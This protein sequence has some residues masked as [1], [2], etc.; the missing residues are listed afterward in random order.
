MGEEKKISMK[1][2]WPST[3]TWVVCPASVLK[4][5]AHQIFDKV[6]TKANLFVLVYHE[7]NRTKDGGELEKNEIV[8]ITCS[9]MSMEVPK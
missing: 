1:K 2:G 8:L 4:Q 6:T 7:S 9:I 5:L 3:G